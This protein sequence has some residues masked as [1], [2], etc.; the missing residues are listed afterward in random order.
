MRVLLSLIFLAVF[1]VPA[2]AHKLP[3]AKEMGDIVFKEVE[4]RAIEKFFGKQAAKAAEG[5]D[6]GK[7]AKKAQGFLLGQVMQRTGGQANP[8]VVSK[9]LAA[10][11]KVT[12][13]TV[14]GRALVS[15]RRHLLHGHL[16][17]HRLYFRSLC[18]LYPGD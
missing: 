13:S 12:L 15:G 14:P 10:K 11:L 8:Q 16:L 17:R 5:D 6:G 7:K 9:L 3:T 1:M 18:L 2:G 4:K